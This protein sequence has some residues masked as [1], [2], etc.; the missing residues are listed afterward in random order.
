MSGHSLTLVLPVYNEAE[1]LD[2]EAI[3]AFLQADDTISLTFVDDGSSDGTARRIEALADR[4]PGRISLLRLEHN[5]GK[6]E[7]VR[8][9]M[10]HG[11]E[12]GAPYVGFADADLAAPLEEVFALRAELERFDAVW[13][14]FGSR[15]K[16]LGRRIRRS[17][18]RH[19]LGRLF[20]TCAS[21]AL[22]LPVYDTQCGLKLFR[23]VPAVR[24]ALAAPFRSRWIFDVEL[25]ARLALEAGDEVERR[26]REVPLERW[27][28]RG[29][30]R[31]RLRDFIRAPLELWQ[32]R[33]AYRSRRA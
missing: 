18:L 11:L 14:A 22:R 5:Q 32:I 27:E 9:G 31:L 7:A 13:A 16:L 21:L 10:V 1:R 8:R 30:S 4:A 12:G 25:I 15:V 20:A 3:L 23:N 33:S 2:G 6:A 29:K 19:Y 24:Q 17:E 28:A 26:L